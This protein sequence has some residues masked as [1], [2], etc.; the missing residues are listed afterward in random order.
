MFS[1]RGWGMGRDGPA[2]DSYSLKM[3]HLNHY[4]EDGEAL[5]VRLSEGPRAL[6]VSLSDTQT[7]THRRLLSPPVLFVFCLMKGNITSRAIMQNSAALLPMSSPEFLICAAAFLYYLEPSRT[8]ILVYPS[9]PL[10]RQHPSASNK[11]HSLRVVREINM[12]VR[13]HIML[14]TVAE[15]RSGNW[16]SR[17]ERKVPSCKSLGAGDIE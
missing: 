4:V 9:L 3:T 10:G 11:T 2:D 14:G 13:T 12:H 8:R 15:G 7:H 16:G 5:K 6:S 1:S 17:A